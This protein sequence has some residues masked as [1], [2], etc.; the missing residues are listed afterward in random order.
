MGLEVPSPLGH[1]LAGV[2]VAL[3]A[4]RAPT[5]LRIEPPVS[6]WVVVACI[7][8]AGLPDADLL[9]A[10][11]HRTATHSLASSVLVAI[12][13]AGV[14][15]RV[16]GRVDWRV[17]ALCG[18]AWASHIALDW[19]GQDYATPQGVQALW[20]WSDEFFISDW[21][22]FRATERRHPLS[23]A[24]IR[25][26]AITALRELLLLGPP[27]AALWFTRGSRRPG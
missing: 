1:A 19:L 25:H 16:T 11:M 2:I 7:A 4:E 22:V 12:I 8:L 20:P 15:R 26:N 24:S 23:P 6:T 21:G 3:S 18:I 9:V 10:G 17:S 27:A 13:A 5:R 14:T